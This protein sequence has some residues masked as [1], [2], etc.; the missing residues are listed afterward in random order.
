MSAS[1][2]DTGLA[3]GT[4]YS[5]TVSAYDPSGNTSAQSAAFGAATSVPVDTTPPTVPAGLKATGA[6]TTSIS[7]SWT[8]ST[9][10]DSPVAGY[11]IF[12]GGT[13]VGTSMS[14]SY[15]DTGLAPGTTYS[16]TVSAYDPSAN[17]SAQS[18]ALMT[19]TNALPDTTPP[20]VPTGLAKT[21]ATSSSIS[22]SW[23]ASTDPDS[24]VAGYNIYRGGTKVGTSASTSYTDTGLSVNTTYSYTVS[25]YD[26]TANTSAQSSPLS[27]TTSS[28]SILVSKNT[29]VGYDGFITYQN[30]GTG[31]EANP[32]VN[33]TVPN[34]AT[35]DKTGCVFSNQGAPGCTAVTCSQSGTTITYAFTG[36]LTAGASL[37][38][39]YST[40]VSGE[41]IATNIFVTAATCP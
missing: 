21:G 1:F 30:K 26:P 31:A 29:Y 37:Q 18:A 8:A 24:P 35:V 32:T 3:P 6:T 40:N 5:Y 14:A 41:P 13:K 25:A 22:L 10:P 33:F 4:T 27:A 19:A 39:Y 17:T 11:N 28:C 2:T 15:T 12:R 23:M 38:V 9:D 34:G 16:Y 20:T 7:L 36:S